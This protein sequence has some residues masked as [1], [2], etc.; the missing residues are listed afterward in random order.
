MK[1]VPAPKPEPVALVEESLGEDSPEVTPFIHTVRWSGETLSV[2]AQWYTGK[3]GN[4]KAVAKAN[5]ALNPHRIFK[6]NEIVIPEKLL[7]TRKPMPKRFVVKATA[8]NAER[9]ET[10]S[11][12]KSSEGPAL[13]LF[14]PK[15]P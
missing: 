5:P 1:P 14:G 6:G 7:E 15:G 10:A 2:V 3:H 4:W 8:R 11:E 9:K 12:L 13:P